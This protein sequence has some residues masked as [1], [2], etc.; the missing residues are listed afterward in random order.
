MT[1]IPSKEE[2]LD[3]M[4]PT[5]RRP[6]NEISRFGLK[7]ADRIDLKRVLKELEA[8]GH[9]EKRQTYRDPNQLPPVSGGSRTRM[10]TV[11]CSRLNGMG[12]EL[13]QSYWLSRVH[14]TRC[15]GQ[16]TVFWPG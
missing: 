11:T 15:W 9:L 8:E 2:V 12:T 5:P 4:L 13:N 3:W 10:R 14:R 7:G 6:P 1:R 16:G